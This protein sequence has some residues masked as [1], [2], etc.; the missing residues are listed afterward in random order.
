MG[1]IG[2]VSGVGIIGVVSSVGITGAVGG[3]WCGES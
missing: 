1:F 2:V 3:G